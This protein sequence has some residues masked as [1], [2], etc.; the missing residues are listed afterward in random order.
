MD[1][2]I[3]SKYYEDKLVALFSLG[4][5]DRIAI[6]GNI[7]KFY[8]TNGS[9]EELTFETYEAALEGMKLIE[10][11][12]NTKQEKWE[13]EFED[14]IQ[15][16]KDICCGVEDIMLDNINLMGLVKK[17]FVLGEFE[18]RAKVKA[19]KGKIVIEITKD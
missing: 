11:M 6:W 13:E 7:I 10:S 4:S 16:E 1:K 15:I 3:I 12:V 17:Y 14:E 8:K 9:I 19:K 5:V 2:P 18:F